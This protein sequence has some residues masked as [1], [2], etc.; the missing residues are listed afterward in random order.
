M[1][2]GTHLGALSYDAE[3]A[4]DRLPQGILLKLM[5][6]LGL[7]AR[8]TGPLR[9][10]HEGLQRRFRVTGSAVGKPFE[11]TNGILQ[12]CPVS[13]ICLNALLAVWARA[14]EDK[15]GVQVSAYADDK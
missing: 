5:E 14:V 6:K 8:I 15:A 10:M 13:V 11:A 2:S 3:K 1:L 12:G 4:F 7:D 9:A